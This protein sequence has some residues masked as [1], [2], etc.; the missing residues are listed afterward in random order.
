MTKH[1]DSPDLSIK[2]KKFIDIM[3]Q[4]FERDSEGC[5]CAPR[6]FRE[7]RQFL[8]SNRTLAFQRANLLTRGLLNKRQHV[9]EFMKKIL[10]NSHAEI[11]PPLSSP[12]EEHW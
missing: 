2:D 9:M 4:G 12:E 7:H 8:Q 10:E 6:P 5:W 3:D 11:A 1:D